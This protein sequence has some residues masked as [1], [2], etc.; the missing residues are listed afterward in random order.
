[1]VLGG[2]IRFEF[3][4]VVRFLLDMEASF[5][6]PLLAV[7]GVTAA[8]RLQDWRVDAVDRLG[9]AWLVVPVIVPLYSLTVFKAV[10]EYAHGRDGDWYSV[11]NGS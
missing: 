10:V 5:V 7:I 1:M 3:A 2:T 9:W 8:V 4:F 6:P 11:E